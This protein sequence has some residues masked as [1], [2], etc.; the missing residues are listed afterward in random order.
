MTSEEQPRRDDQRSPGGEADRA[1]NAVDVVEGEVGSA[2][3]KEPTE[4]EAERARDAVTD[5]PA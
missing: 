1:E 2:R 3:F 4:V 5:R